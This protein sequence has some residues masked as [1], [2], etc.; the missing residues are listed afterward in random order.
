MVKV[1]IKLKRLNVL[2]ITVPKQENHFAVDKKG[3]FKIQITIVRLNILN[4]WDIN[5]EK[6]GVNVPRLKYDDIIFHTIIRIEYY[7]N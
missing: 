7:D 5:V 2:L 3:F 1:V 6:L 4:A